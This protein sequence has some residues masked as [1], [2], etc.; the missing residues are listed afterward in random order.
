MD[1]VAAVILLDQIPRNIYRGKE[2]QKV[3]DT[4]ISTSGGDR[5]F[6]GRSPADSQAYTQ[7]DPKALELAKTLLGEGYGA[8][9][10]C[11]C[12]VGL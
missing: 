7:Y 2:A 12:L 11:E 4:C 6:K 10:K 1:E 9:E 3:S 8:R 5:C